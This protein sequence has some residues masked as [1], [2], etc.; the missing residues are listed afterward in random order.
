MRRSLMK[1]REFF[2]A[3]AICGAASTLP[4]ALAQE[5]PIST[6]ENGPMNQIPLTSSAGTR[7]GDM[8]YRTLGRTGERVSAIGMG[9]F[10]IA[11]HGLTE[12]ESIRLVRA[13]V[14]RGI[15]FMDNS[16][17]YNEGQSEMRMG[18]ALKD[19]YRQKVF[20]MTK[21][22]GRTKEVAE[23]QIETCL[24]R[25]QTD[26]IDLVQFH[27]SP[28]RAELEANDSVAMIPIAYLRRAEPWKPFWRPRK[29]ARFA[30]SDSP[31]TKIRTF[32]CIC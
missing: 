13:A 9:G 30:T 28:S 2:K 17:D 1:R 6:Q 3:A 26:H 12:D 5:K 7:K 31:V 21:I 14:D 24:E 10:H 18:K 4:A 32:I 15:T 25:L 23:R 19:G 8:L 22:D 20:L 16:W 29:R 27:I 11:Q